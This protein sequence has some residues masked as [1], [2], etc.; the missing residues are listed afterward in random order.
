R[1]H[2]AVC[3]VKMMVR[4]ALRHQLRSALTVLGLV[5]ATLSF[6]LLQTVVDAWYAG[7]QAASGTTL[8]TRNATSL[9]FPLPLSY[10]GKIR[11]VEGVSGVA[12]ANWFGGVYQD[13][14]N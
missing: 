9:V 2:S 4:N 13:P 10:A 3:A 8:V 6:G 12:Y 5:V 14:K 1:A 11:A 7:A